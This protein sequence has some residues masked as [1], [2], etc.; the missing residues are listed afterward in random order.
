MRIERE[1]ARWS[2]PP[3]LLI[4]PLAANLPFGAHHRSVAAAAAAKSIVFCSNK[5]TFRVCVYYC[6]FA[7]RPFDRPFHHD[8]Y[9][10]T[11]YIKR[12]ISD[13]PIQVYLWENLLKMYF[14]YGTHPLCNLIITILDYFFL[15]LFFI[16]SIKWVRMWSAL[17]FL[18]FQS[19]T[20][21]ESHRISL[22]DWNLEVYI[23]I[24]VN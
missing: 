13:N 20:E 7:L 1:T 12:T 22:Q 6:V 9:S 14:L 4:D 5:R 24:L 23:H 21:R 16:G 19:K 2:F 11:G 18:S 15:S 17:I 8:Y 10:L 3:F